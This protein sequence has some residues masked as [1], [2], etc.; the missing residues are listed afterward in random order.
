MKVTVHQ[1]KV[2]NNK[3]NTGKRR[4][5]EE[6]KRKQATDF[7]EAVCCPSAGV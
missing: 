2:K 4:A 7:K 5:G 6:R 3:R 1:E